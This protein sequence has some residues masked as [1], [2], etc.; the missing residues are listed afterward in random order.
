MSSGRVWLGCDES[1]VSSRPAP[2]NAALEAIPSLAEGSVREL[3][4]VVV[5]D[6]VEVGQVKLSGLGLKSRLRVVVDV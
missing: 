3:V 6:G 5:P 2:I 4:D 1:K